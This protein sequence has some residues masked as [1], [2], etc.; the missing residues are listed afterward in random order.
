MRNK[1]SLQII[2]EMT[3]KIN[4]ALNN[5]TMLNE[6]R[7]EY[8]QNECTTIF[9][10]VFKAVDE[11]VNKDKSEDAYERLLI[12]LSDR[13][14]VS[15]TGGDISRQVDQLSSAEFLFEHQTQF[16]ELLDSAKDVIEFIGDKCEKIEG[17][18]IKNAKTTSDVDT[19]KQQETE[20]ESSEEDIENSEKAEK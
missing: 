14:K 12:S 5:L 19:N 1:S 13:F 11:Y 16:Q 4:N 20:E 9:D 15:S 10:N 3:Y 8:T 6:K 2:K 17:I 18:S 7:Y